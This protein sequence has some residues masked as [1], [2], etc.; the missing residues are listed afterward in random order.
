MYLERL[1]DILGRVSVRY[2]NDVWFLLL[3][4]LNEEKRNRSFAF[5]PR[6]DC[7]SGVV[8][9]F[10]SSSFPSAIFLHSAVISRPYVAL[11]PLITHSLNCLPMINDLWVMRMITIGFGE[12]H[13]CRRLGVWTV[14]CGYG[15]AFL[16][17]REPVGSSEFLR[18]PGNS[19]A[20]AH[21][22]GISPYSIQP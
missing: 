15:G 2:A 6:I 22:P 13:V 5:R 3:L 18:L 16:C 8:C 17:T 21:A 4:L 7:F 12:H 10:L 1:H 11:S 20:R 19:S 9:G 14:I